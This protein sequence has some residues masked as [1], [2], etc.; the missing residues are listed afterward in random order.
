MD[1]WTSVIAFVVLAVLCAKSAPPKERAEEH[2]IYTPPPGAPDFDGPHGSAKG[3]GE[4][5]QW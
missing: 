4:P 5:K 3:T 1:T 2:F